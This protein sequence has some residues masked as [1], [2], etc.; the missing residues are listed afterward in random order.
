MQPNTYWY[1]TERPSGL[2]WTLGSAKPRTP[3]IVP[4]YYNGQNTN[5]VDVSTLFR[6]N[7]DTHVLEGP[8]FHHEHDDMLDIPEGGS[9]DGAGKH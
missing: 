5:F 4:K 1:Q 7:I 8:V 6:R 9:I 3:D 2:I